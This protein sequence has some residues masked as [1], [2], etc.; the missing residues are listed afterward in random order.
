MGSLPQF[1]QLAGV[2]QDFDAVWSR[3]CS[4]LL[5]PYTPGNKYFR[6][7]LCTLKEIKE[8]RNLLA[9]HPFL[10]AIGGRETKMK[11]DVKFKNQGSNVEE[12]FKSPRIGTVE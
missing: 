3:A 9:M 4:P 5:C 10:E 1:T 7:L 2:R 12:T 11:T 6:Q 8:N